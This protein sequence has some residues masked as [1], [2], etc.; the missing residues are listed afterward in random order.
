VHCGQLQ[1]A[2]ER[3]KA[4]HLRVACAGNEYLFLADIDRGISRV[5]FVYHGMLVF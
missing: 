1:I 5:Y 4:A 3:A 2:A